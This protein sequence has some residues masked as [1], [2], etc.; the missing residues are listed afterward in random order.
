[1]KPGDV[2]I[3]VGTS[4]TVQPAAS[5]PIDAAAAG[6]HIIECN[7]THTPLTSA[8]EDRPD[9]RNIFLGGVGA[10]AAVTL[11]KLVERVRALKA[12]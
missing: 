2:M 8:V 9:R 7:L 5:L 1:M 10:G 6:A 11:P 12:A 3:V 4:G